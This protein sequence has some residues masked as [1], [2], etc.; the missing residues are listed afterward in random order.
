MNILDYLLGTPSEFI[1]NDVAIEERSYHQPNKTGEIKPQRDSFDNNAFIQSLSTTVSTKHSEED[2][3]SIPIAKACRDKITGA[4]KDL[5]IEL[6]KRVDGVPIK[7]ED[8]ERLVL[9]N[10]RPN[11]TDTA[12]SFKEKMVS[13]IVLHGN[14]YVYIKRKGNKIDSLWNMSPKTVT[15]QLYKNSSL[16]FIVENVQYRITGATRPLEYE[17]VMVSVINSDS[18]GVSGRG[19]IECGSRTIEL[20]LNEMRTMNALM[21]NGVAPSAILQ[22]DGKLS[23][24]VRENIRKTMNK[25]Y[26]GSANKGRTMLLEEGLKYTKMSLTPQEL[27]MFES[28]SQSKSDMCKLFGVPEQIV[29]SASNTYGSVEATN[30]FFL[31]YSVSP[32]LTVIEEGLNNFILTIKEQADGYFFKFNTDAILQTTLKERYDALKVGL[33]AGL[34]SLNESRLKENLEPL[35]DEEDF[36]RF[37]L[38]SVFYYRKDGQL[39]VPNTATLFDAGSKEVISVMGQD[40]D[41]LA[42]QQGL[43]APT[44]DEEP[45]EETSEQPTDGDK[46]LE[47]QPVTDEKPLEEAPKQPTDK[48]KP[49]KTKAKATP[50][51]KSASKDEP[52]DKDKPT[53]KAPKSNKKPSPQKQGEDE[54]PKKKRGNKQKK[55]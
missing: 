26:E 31:Q 19:V 27:G 8:D 55:E 37:S 6:F 52:T 1:S 39:F 14:S 11:L 30:I 15:P 46:P 48:A 24:K 16:P 22:A 29:D 2:V 43:E 50:K 34:I 23:D 4:I 21:E 54:A 47:E 40:V 38:G 18:S 33:D 42:A 51:G 28:R 17:N 53:D 12:S 7:I 25:M 45:L 9:L 5:P 32:I 49:T 44:D 20:A 3:L 35:S 41:A 13:D 36:F 10:M